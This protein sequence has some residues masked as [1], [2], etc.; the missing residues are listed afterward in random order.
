MTFIL[1]T[2]A[3][4][5]ALGACAATQPPAPVTG[6]RPRLA[7]V[8]VV[9]GLPQRQAVD[10][11]DQLSPDGLERFFT[12][13]VWFT[14]AHYGYANTETA[15]GHATI[16]TGAYPHRSG[17]IANQWLEP[18]T[19]AL[20]YCFADPEAS[21]IGH[22]TAPREGTSPR[23][24]LVEALGDA[25]KHADARSKVIAIAD[26]DRG[27]IAPAGKRG[28]AYIYRE[29]TG[30]FA[31]TTYYMKEHPRWV[32][33]FNAAKHADRYLGAEWKPLLAEGAYARSQPGGKLPHKLAAQPGPKYYEEVMGTPFGDDLMLQFARAAVAGEQL[34]RDGSPDL[35]FVSLST[36]DYLNHA[37][38]AESRISHDHV[39][40][41]DRALQEFFNDLDVAIGRENY[42]AVLTADH[43]FTPVPEHSQS[44]GRDAG[45]VHPV[46]LLAR[47]NEGLVKKYGAGRWVLGF[48]A[49]A[50]VL[51]HPLARSRAIALDE[52]ANET[53][54]LLVTEPGILRAYTR[55]EL[56]GAPRPDDALFEA[57]RKSWHPQRSADLHMV[58][59]PYWL[60]GSHSGGTTH[61]SPHSYDTNVPL[62]LYGPAWIPAVGR[63]DKRV[64]ISDIAPTLAKLLGVPPPAQSE[65]RPL[66]MDPLAR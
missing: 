56:Q 14:E 52:L 17:I 36:H 21:Y 28:T 39:L 65:G 53:R 24:L 23:N 4:A 6:G 2:L 9:D 18:S 25:L 43:G 63:I 54:K 37:Y 15:P 48:S 22:R 7:V 40:Y 58:L 19:G 62:M 13:G 8:I 45:R 64:E 59:K 61:G 41:V 44:V 35:L 47:L 12:R 11:R 57:A 34:G 31:S 27:A 1:Q 38:G 29:D 26:K 60:L 32:S 50:L 3:L 5:L 55:A 10:Y 30:L 20:T 49:H 33:D 42:L 51:N 66:P 46:R 16:A